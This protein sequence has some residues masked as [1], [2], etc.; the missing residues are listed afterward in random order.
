TDTAGVQQW[1]KYY[2]DERNE[3]VTAVAPASDGG[4][5]LC[6]YAQDLFDAT[7]YEGF[8]IKADATGA[9]L[10][11]KG[12]AALGSLRAEDVTA[13]PDGGCAVTVTGIWAC[14]GCQQA[15][16]LRF[17]PAGNV[18][19]ERDYAS[20]ISDELRSVVRTATDGHLVIGGRYDGSPII[21]KLAST[22]GS[23][24]WASVP[25]DTNGT[26]WSSVQHLAT[27]ASGDRVSAVG[28]TFTGQGYVAVFNDAGQQL[29]A[30]PFP[31]N[32]STL[33]TL[34]TLILPNG[35]VAVIA[36][37]TSYVYN[38][39]GALLVN[40]T[41]TS[42]MTFASV[43]NDVAATADNR[44]AYA[45]LSRKNFNGDDAA[46]VLSTDAL[47]VQ[48][49]EAYGTTGPNHN[50][51][52]YMARQTPDGGYILVGAKIYADTQ[53]DLYVIKTD[54]AGNVQWQ[55]RYGGA[56]AETPRSVRL[57]P[58][59]GYI[60]SG[61]VVGTTGARLWH[62]LKTNAAGVPQWEKAYD[63]GNTTSTSSSLVIP[64]AGGGYFGYSS[65]SLTGPTNTRRPLLIRLTENG[66]TLWTKKIGTGSNNAFRNMVQTK[67]G[68]LALSGWSLTTPSGIW[69][70][71]LS[72]QGNLLWE[73]VVP[74]GIGYGV[75][76]LP[77]QSLVYTGYYDVQTTNPDSL[78]FT[79]LSSGGT[80]LSQRFFH[81]STGYVWPRAHIAPDGNVL[82]TVGIGNANSDS[83]LILKTSP[84]GDMLWQQKHQP[85]RDLFTP[86][87]SI[88]PDGSVLMFGYG[89]RT[90]SQDYMLFKA[91]K[92]GLVG[93]PIVP[94]GR[95]ELLLAP[96]PSAGPLQI[97][98]SSDQTGPAS[99]RL[100]DAMGRSMFEAHADKNSDTL[101]QS[102][103][104]SALPAGTYFWQVCVGGRCTGSN[105]QKH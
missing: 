84:D 48:K 99:F 59:G 100:F 24:L 12:F 10:W 63:L 21:S 30:K 18:L 94:Q 4:Y 6:G 104:L 47:A 77:D 67:Q 85:C 25:V 65:G 73:K 74:G 69:M 52:G 53:D 13:M 32:L 1:V 40:A 92:D 60:F 3:R 7:D 56:T 102:F 15:G 75:A 103:D 39:A 62:V 64:A 86:D 17:G 22:T 37:R 58:D 44:L 88:N 70:L 72:A 45:A 38:P 80:V 11:K 54:A 16:V 29:W 91:T 20:L 81:N 23:T 41:F 78:S 93:T 42:A 87:G 96:N 89:R 97:T 34:K 9:Q 43:V 28:I 55:N 51:Q 49:Y 8:I 95:A 76:E 14:Q 27:N 83:L 101:T 71:K 5:F 50:E 105:W 31:V 98:L 33:Q 61:H 46:L 90:T 19:W 66:D 2:G 79:H 82:I 26:S 68:D 36:D 57:T 35:K